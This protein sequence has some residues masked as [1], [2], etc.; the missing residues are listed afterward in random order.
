MKL[1]VSR[2]K[3]RVW[4]FEWAMTSSQ[5]L[6]NLVQETVVLV[7]VRN[8]RRLKAN[9]LKLVKQCGRQT[10]KIK[11]LRFEM[12][13]KWRHSA[14]IFHYAVN[15]IGRG[16][17]GKFKVRFRGKKSVGIQSCG[18]NTFLDVLETP[19]PQKPCWP[20]RHFKIISPIKAKLT[21]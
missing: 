2:C 7:V 14:P 21:N 17:I 13:L 11:A 6:L 5:E 8:S 15:L 10:S 19:K 16:H 3:L 18:L 20:Y 9:K 1:T 4:V 12:F